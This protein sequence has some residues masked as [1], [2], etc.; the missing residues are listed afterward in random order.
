LHPED[1]ELLVTTATLILS[2]KLYVRPILE[3]SSPVWS[4]HN[5]QLIIR[6]KSVQRA[7][8]KRLRGYEGL[9]Y[10]ERL[11]KAG[12]QSL[13]LRRKRTDLIVCYNILHNIVDIPTMSNLF[14]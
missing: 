3:Y 1:D 12:L 10:K 7:F 14:L 8:T 9:S 4:P 11:N 6:L 5:L 13:E 2:F